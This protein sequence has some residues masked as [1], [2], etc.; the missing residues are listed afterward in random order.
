MD[1]SNV[2]EASSVAHTYGLDA[3]YERRG[4]REK[5]GKALSYCPEPLGRWF[6]YLITLERPREKWASCVSWREE[7]KREKN[8]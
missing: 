2:L 3:V 4:E 7:R 1:S 8:I 6:R 5:S